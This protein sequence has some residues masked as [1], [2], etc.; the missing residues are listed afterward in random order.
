MRLMSFRKKVLPSGMKGFTRL[1]LKRR[2]MR[3]NHSLTRREN[4]KALLL[5]TG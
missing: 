5:I 2:R 4:Q 3:T 1:T